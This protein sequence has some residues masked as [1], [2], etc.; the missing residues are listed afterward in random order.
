MLRGGGGTAAA[1]S[2]PQTAGE[3]EGGHPSD[4]PEK[5]VGMDTREGHRE[6]MKGRMT[7]MSRSSRV[8]LVYT[9]LTV[10]FALIE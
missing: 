2:N 4:S 1:V 10:F 5:E 9:T 6:K 3:Q 7:R 8:Q